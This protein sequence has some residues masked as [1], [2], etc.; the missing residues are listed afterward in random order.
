MFTNGGGP[1]LVDPSE[2]RPP[3]EDRDWFQLHLDRA[4]QHPDELP[5]GCTSGK[6]SWSQPGVVEVTGVFDHAAAA[7][8]TS[9]GDRGIL[10]WNDG[11]GSNPTAEVDLL[12]GA[13]L[14]IG[15]TIYSP[16]GL[17]R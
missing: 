8:C 10:I 3:T 12:G 4:G 2:T 14:N 7:S 5:V 13:D 17:V 1:L 9:R 16:K 11:N 15:G 6:T